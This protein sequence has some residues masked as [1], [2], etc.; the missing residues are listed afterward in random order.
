MRGDRARCA[1]NFLSDL[2]AGRRFACFEN[3]SRDNTQNLTPGIVAL[4]FSPLVGFFPSFAQRFTFFGVSSPP[5]YSGFPAT[6]SHG[7]QCFAACA[8]LAQAAIGL[9][10]VGDALGDVCADAA[11]HGE[12]V[13]HWWDVWLSVVGSDGLGNVVS[14]FVGVDELVVFESFALG[15]ESVPSD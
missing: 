1:P 6:L 12:T 8:R 14:A 5:G 15:L 9:I 7:G 3:R 11:G 13:S 10:R 4:H 2:S